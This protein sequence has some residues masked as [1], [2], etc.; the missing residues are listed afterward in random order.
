MNYEAYTQYKAYLNRIWL[1]VT[2]LYPPPAIRT[3]ILLVFGSL[4]LETL[5]PLDFVQDIVSIFISHKA[6]VKLSNDL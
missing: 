4:S 6:L 3:I 1:I 2:L 5:P